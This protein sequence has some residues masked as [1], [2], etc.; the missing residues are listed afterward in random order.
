MSGN[1]WEW[2][3]DFYGAYPAGPVTDPA[4]ATSGS[5]RVIR[6]GGWYSIARGARSANRYNISPDFI[7]INL[8][9]RLVLPLARISHEHC[10]NFMKVVS[11]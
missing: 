1:V 3:E 9:F 6:G 10:V 7:N 2:C 8:G 11:L 5:N 4:G